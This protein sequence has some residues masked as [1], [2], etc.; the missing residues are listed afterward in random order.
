MIYIHI[1][2]CR[3]F[4]T[5]CDFYSEIP[6]GCGTG[7]AAEFQPFVDALCSEIAFRAAEIPFEHNTLY[8]GGGTPSVLPLCDLQRIVAALPAGGFDEFTIEVNPDDI[9]SHGIEYVRGLRQLGVNRV[10]MG[11]QS[12]DD[13]VLRWMNRRHNAAAARQAYRLLLDGGIDNISIDL[14]FGFGSGIGSVQGASLSGVG[15]GQPGEN[16]GLS[17][18]SGLWERTIEEALDIG[19]DGVPPRHISAYQLSVEPG[20]AL[21]EMVAD[22]RYTE[23]SDELCA[24]QYETLCRRLAEAG[25]DHYEVSNFAQPGYEARHNSAYWQHTPY[26]GFGPAAHSFLPDQR[27]ESGAA[28]LGA[29]TGQENPGSAPSGFI[30]R[31]NKPDV[32]AYIKAAQIG[33]WS[34]ISDGEILTAD[35]FRTE[36]IMLSL[37]TD[38]GIERDFLAPD[39]H[40]ETL[41]ATGALVAAGDRLRIPEDHFFV[42]D[43]IISDLI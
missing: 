43:D 19:G 36:K 29:L 21:A 28:E 11:V 32:S 6:A 7:R 10:S 5:Y 33:D 26:I 8:I 27:G 41:L 18:C 25:Y 13:G 30:R 2:Y 23:A 17:G 38:K 34:S 14:I 37:R 42:S 16:A 35:Q 39:A 22:G 31:W 1:P 24:R 4:C 20:S 12:M 40:I 3:S 9:V 15:T